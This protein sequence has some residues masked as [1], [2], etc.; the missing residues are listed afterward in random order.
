MSKNIAYDMDA[1]D[2]DSLDRL[3]RKNKRPDNWG[4]KKHRG[5]DY[6]KAR[7]ERQKERERLEREYS[8]EEY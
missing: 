7:K 5:R 6:S 2:E 4:K 1:Y 3:E 8:D